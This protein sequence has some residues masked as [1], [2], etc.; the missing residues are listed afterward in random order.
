MRKLQ[1]TIGH[2]FIFSL[3]NIFIIY[4][5]G[6]HSL[7]STNSRVTSNHYFE[8]NYSS[9]E[10]NI[11]ISHSQ[12]LNHCEQLKLQDS[13]ESVD[14]NESF[15]MIRVLELSSRVSQMFV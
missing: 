1:T 2:I 10:Q 15:R 14:T 3:G 5:F 12:K 6:V 7:N 8:Q 13:L 9:I 4:I 11:F